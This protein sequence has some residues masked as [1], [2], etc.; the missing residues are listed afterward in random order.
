M[1]SMFSLGSHQQHTQHLTDSCESA[2]INLTNIDRVRL[3]QLLEHHTVMRMFPSRNT[4][5]VRLEC[6]PDRGMAKSI[7]WCRRLLN[8]PENVNIEFCGMKANK[9]V[10]TKA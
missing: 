3:E 6:T 1:K 8:E 9:K 4:N 5:S 2:C 7:I 10:Q